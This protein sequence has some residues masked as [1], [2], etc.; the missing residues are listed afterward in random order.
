MKIRENISA[1]YLLLGSVFLFSACGGNAATAP[2]Q[3][4]AEP[5]IV[6]EANSQ[7]EPSP[8][9]QIPN[10]QAEIL[11][12]RNK[13]TASPIGN[14]DF[15]NFTY[16]FPRGWQDV[17][18]R[19]FTLENGKRQMSADKIGLSYMTTKF[20]DATG[21][22]EEEAFVILKIDTAGSAI[23]QIV[24][25]FTMKDNQPELIWHFRT[26]DR[27]DGGLKDIRPENGE[28]VIE[29]YGQDRYIFGEVETLKITGDNQQICCPTH[30]TRTRYKWNGGSFP[31]QG[32]RLTFSMKNENEPP[33]EN[34]G[35][36]I[37]K[38]N[39]K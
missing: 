32:K 10:L 4:N 36:L 16:P 37:E 20:F 8:A 31:M 3:V 35:E 18:S 29:I 38:E 24:Y 33:V 13:T 30:Y 15:K 7:S 19:E 12:E 1:I 9:S 39:K 11:D 2:S 5:T 27:S 22:N 34:M 21:D 14:I 25:V 6:L 26:G 17:D 28:V 23:P